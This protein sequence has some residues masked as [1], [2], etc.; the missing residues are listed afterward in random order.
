M[1]PAMKKKVLRR[2]SYGLYIVTVAHKREQNGFTA[3]WLSQSS[4]EPPMLTVALE[5]DARSLTMIESSRAF[6]VNVVAQDGRDLAGQ[7]G[8]SSH[9]NP[10]K[11][12]NLDHTPGP[13]TG[14]PILAAAA[15]WVECRLVAT[16]PSG[17]HTLLLGEIVEAG[18]GRD[19]PPLTHS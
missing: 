5:S 13:A 10:N 8:R 12:A 14:S 15:G 6:A 1:D 11:L 3:N 2:F 4:F 7:L 16:L 9:Q 18:E 19:L 17:D